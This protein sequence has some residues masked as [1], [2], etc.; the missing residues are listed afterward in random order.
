MS[1]E[2]SAIRLS[3][4]QCEI[5]RRSRDPRF[6]GRFIV[7]VVTTGVYCRPVCPAPIAAKRNVRY[8]ASPAAAQDAGYRP[9]L[10]CCPERA[11]RLPE[12]CLPDETLNRALRLVDAG[13]LDDASVEALAARVGLSSRHLVR[14]FSA[15]LGTTPS[16]LART[17]RIQLAKRLL[18]DTDLPMTV[19]AMHAGFGSLRRF[20]DQVAAA[21]G[22]APSH[23]RKGRR[24][25]PNVPLQLN[26]AHREPYDARWVF[27]FLARRVLVGVEEVALGEERMVYRRRLGRLENDWLEVCWDAQ[28]GLTLT[29]PT[30]SRVSLSSVLPRVRRMFDLDCDP[31]VVDGYLRK[32]PRLRRL[33]GTARGLR[34]PGAWDGYETAVR[35]LLG[36]QVSVDRATRLA[37]DLMQHYGGGDFPAP[38]ALAHAEVAEIGMPGQR[39][40]AISELARRVASGELV[41]DESRDSAELAK[42]LCSIKGLGPWTA[43]YIAL[44]IARDPDA[45]PE[46]DWVVLK[47]LDATP[48]AVRRQA[49]AWRPWRSY[50]L[51][52]LWHAEGVRRAQQMAQ[53]Q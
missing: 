4:E 48:A 1:L 25:R 30:D 47:V 24:G 9:C 44:R 49:E 7:A 22:A 40:R 14:L 46:S 36:Q 11:P 19:V 39:G 33:M 17:R 45:F 50:A 15:H 37:A 12:W 2:H 23:L 41:I 13:F 43:S 8:Y 27:E 34:V 6:D 51:M 5:A 52:Y 32:D 29:L 53:A 10:R 21:Y 31:A 28:Q 35:A 3:A 18:D 42:Q 20:N 38:Q 26:L 16:N